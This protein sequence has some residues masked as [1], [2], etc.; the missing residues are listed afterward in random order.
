MIYDQIY[1][2]HPSYN[3]RYDAKVAIV[4]KWAKAIQPNKVLDVGCGRGHYL[5]DLTKHGYSVVGIEPSKYACDKLEKYTV[6]NTDI[7]GAKPN[8]YDALYC[9]D[10]LEHISHEELHTNLVALAKLAPRALIGVANHSDRW[11]N[12]ELHLIQEN[13]DW[14]WNTLQ[15]VY[16]D[17]TLVKEYERFYVFDCRTT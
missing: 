7:L 8:N 1:E 5:K 16:K 17:I 2:Q 13:V 10:V 4:R 15:N 14:W 3:S 12:V 11:E 6:I 9:M